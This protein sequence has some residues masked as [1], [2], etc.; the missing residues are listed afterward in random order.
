MLKDTRLADLENQARQL[1][2]RIAALEKDLGD[3]VARADSSNK[4]A[5]ALAVQLEEAKAAAKK[6]ATVVVSA[7]PKTNA[8]RIA[9][10]LAIKSDA[11]DIKDAIMKRVTKD[12]K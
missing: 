11:L 1:N 4:R 7:P 5:E 3:A 8:E 10:L 6:S 12:S 9:R 2:G